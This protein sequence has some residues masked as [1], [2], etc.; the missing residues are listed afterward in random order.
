[1][2]SIP[3]ITD[4]SEIAPSIFFENIHLSFNGRRLFDGLS[5]TAERG[6]C[7]SILGPSG[8]G[9]STLLKIVSGNSTIPFQGTVRFSNNQRGIG[10]MSQNDLL[11][12]WM[13]LL[14]N[15]LL[16][17][18]LRGEITVTLRNRAEHLL[19]AAGLIDYKDEMPA[20]LSGGMRQRGALLRT[21]MEERP[22]LLM[23]EPFSALDALTRLKLQNL[24]AKMT[25]GR[26]VLLVTHDP[27]EAL[28]ISDEILV[29][30][31]EPVG[32]SKITSLP[33]AIPRSPD[34]QQM[35]PFY[36]SLLEKLGVTMQ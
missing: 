35:V 8:C 24:A 30:S 31:G 26:T 18:K 17:A 12:P 10:W 6:K 29:F 23:D 14:E 36:S 7:T 5:F 28:R 33:G 19:E 34:N 25:R 11:L 4:F 9:K 3:E 1:M 22:V 20:T 2:A 16:G 13:S 21:L 27:L 15:V 32:L